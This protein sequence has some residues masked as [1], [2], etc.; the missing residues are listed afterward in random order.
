MPGLLT[1]TEESSTTPTSLRLAGS[2]NAIY[3]IDELIKQRASTFGD[4]TLLC[5]P[6][7]GLTDY[8]EHSARAI[9]GY[10]DAAADALQRRGLEQAVGGT[11]HTKNSLLTAT[12]GLIARSSADG[13]NTGSLV[14]G[15][16]HYP[17]WTEQVGICR[18]SSFASA[19]QSSDNV[20]TGAS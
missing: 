11:E 18:P 4:S 12:T 8:E 10:V 1:K 15:I 20:I 14:P 17:A 3:T 16:H 6:K 13:C 19:R 5:F 2:D 7:E 9:D